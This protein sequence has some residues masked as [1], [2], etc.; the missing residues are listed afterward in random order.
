MKKRLKVKNII[1]CLI[2]LF[3]LFGLISPFIFINISLI[4]DKEVILNYGDKYSEPG[5]RAK[6]F[7]KNIT[8]DIKVESDLKED[9]GKYK[10]IYSYKFL[11]YKI[12]KVRNIEVKD[13]EK[14][15]NRINWW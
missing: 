3:I 5:Y 14:T 2:I 8:T 7:N 9:I 6:I 12:K 10:I 1:I 15:K 4:G 13:I 11:F